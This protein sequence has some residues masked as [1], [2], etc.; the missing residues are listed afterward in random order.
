MKITKE[1]LKQIV[2]EELMQVLDET[3]SLEEGFEEPEMKEL[4]LIVSEINTL[5]DKAENLQAIPLE[6]GTGKMLKG[7]TAAYLYGRKKK[8]GLKGLR[9]AK[10]L[11]T[12]ERSVTMTGAKG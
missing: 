1:N 3:N 11:K 4:K 6:P 10:P 8:R 9:G 2:K 7:V 5:I 12:V